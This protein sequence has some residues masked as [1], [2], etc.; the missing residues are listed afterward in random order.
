MAHAW[1]LPAESVRRSEVELSGEALGDGEGDGSSASGD[2][3]ADDEGEDS[4]ASGEGVVEDEGAGSP[5]PPVG[6][7]SEMEPPT[8]NV[9][10]SAPAP[11][12][13]FVHAPS[14]TRMVSNDKRDRSTNHVPQ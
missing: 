2:G 1:V 11:F 7:Y 14:E 5:P 8:E 4:S 3:L 10:G 12:E 6:P 13:A 9:G